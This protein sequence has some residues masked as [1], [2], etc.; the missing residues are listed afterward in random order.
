MPPIHIASTYVLPGAGE[1]AEFD[2]SRT[3]TPT[4]QRLEQTVASL[5][6][7]RRVG[8]LS[9]HGRDSWGDVVA[10]GGRYCWL[11][12]IST[13]ARIACCTRCFRSQASKSRSPTLVI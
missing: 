12:P 13:A 9:G 2:Y 1:P 6:E 10:Q 4:R 3:A 7:G 5:E 11:G 8:L